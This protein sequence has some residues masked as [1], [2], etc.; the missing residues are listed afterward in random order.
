[1]K[2]SGILMEQL[3]KEFQDLDF[4]IGYSYFEKSN[5]HNF[6]KGNAAKVR[7]EELKIP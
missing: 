5:P 7:E 2:S 1:M 6:Y 3:T 4:H